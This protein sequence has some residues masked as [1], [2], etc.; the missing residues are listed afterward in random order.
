MNLSLIIDNVHRS[1][2]IQDYN[3]VLQVVYPESGYTD[4]YRAAS[5]VNISLTVLCKIMIDLELMEH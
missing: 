3:C 4:E 1:D 2:S 5:N